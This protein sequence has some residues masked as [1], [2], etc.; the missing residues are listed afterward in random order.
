MQRYNQNWAQIRQ[1]SKFFITHVA[2][3]HFYKLPLPN[4][5]H[6]PVNANGHLYLRAI[7]IEV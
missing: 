2:L 3:C 7:L 6:A 1:I 4:L 5:Q